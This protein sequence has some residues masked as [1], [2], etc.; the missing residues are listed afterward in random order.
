MRSVQACETSRL[1]PPSPIADQGLFLV[2]FSSA[3][4]SFA[5][6]AKHVLSQLTS[7]GVSRARMIRA[8]DKRDSFAEPY[9][10]PVSEACVWWLEIMLVSNRSHDRFES[11]LS[12]A[13]NCVQLF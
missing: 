4:E 5:D 9:H 10:S 13:Q 12:Q 3:H 1:G 2:I 7:L 6:R 8:Y 11:E